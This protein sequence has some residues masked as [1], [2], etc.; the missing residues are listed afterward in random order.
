MRWFAIQRRLFAALSITVLAGGMALLSGSTASAAP[1]N[2]TNFGLSMVARLE[3]GPPPVPPD[4]RVG[5]TL[6][7]KVPL[8]GIVD[9]AG[10]I[11][12][13][14]GVSLG[15]ITDPLD[16]QSDSLLDQPLDEVRLFAP[17]GFTGTVDP[18]AGTIDLAAT[19]VAFTFSGNDSGHDYECTTNLPGDGVLHLHSSDYNAGSGTGTLEAD[20]SFGLLAFGYGIPECDNHDGYFNSIYPLPSAPDNAVFSVAIAF[21]PAITA[22]TP[23]GPATTPQTAPPASGGGT[24]GGAASGAPAVRATGKLVLPTGSLRHARRR[25]PRLRSQRARPSPRPGARRRPRRPPTCGRAAAATS[26]PVSSTTR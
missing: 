6:V 8:T 20:A 15:S 14:T 24:G 9:G 2:A 16:R 19:A 5:V 23:S 18:S 3:V 1:T 13:S 26:R 4:F 21:N 22:A 25:R 11:Q 7:P 17:N 12:T 10:N